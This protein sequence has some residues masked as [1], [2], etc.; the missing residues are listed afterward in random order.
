LLLRPPPLLPPLRLPLLL[1][2]P[3]PLLF[4]FL[5]LFLFPVLLR[6]PAP[7]PP[8]LLL[9]VSRP[10]QNK[11]R[12]IFSVRLSRPVSSMAEGVWLSGLSGRPGGSA[13]WLAGEMD[14][15]G[16]QRPRLL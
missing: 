5:F 6:L 2:L 16:A 15:S 10:G 11:K 7:H 1:L 8:P 4:L 14:R 9:R 13:G 12:Y 3:A